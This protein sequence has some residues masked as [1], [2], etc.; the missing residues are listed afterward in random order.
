M[1]LKATPKSMDDVY[2]CIRCIITKVKRNKR[3]QT[4]SNNTFECVRGG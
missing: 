3:G 1:E 2:D 4:Q